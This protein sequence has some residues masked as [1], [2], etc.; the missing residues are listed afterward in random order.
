[1]HTNISTL[2]FLDEITKTW[3]H[4]ELAKDGPWQTKR[5][6]KEKVNCFFNFYLSGDQNAIDLRGYL[7]TSDPDD[8]WV[9]SLKTKIV[10]YIHNRLV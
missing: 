1:M 9:N 6:L 10:P 2:D 3:L 7:T 4:V 8:V 5:T